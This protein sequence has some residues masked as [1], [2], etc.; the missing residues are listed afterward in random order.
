MNESFGWLW[1]F[2][3]VV[4]GAVLGLGFLQAEF[5]GGYGSSR[6]RLLRLGHISFFGLGLLN[7]LFGCSVQADTSTSVALE[8]AGAG[9][10]LAG[11][12]MPIA[13]ALVAWRQSL[14]PLFVIPVSA[15]LVATGIMAWTALSGEATGS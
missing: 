10:L 9:F 2:W 13:C 5:L 15:A 12:F 4:S 1:I 3:G 7:I 11:L 14:H 8:V 6:R